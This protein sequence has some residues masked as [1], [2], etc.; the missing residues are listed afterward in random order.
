MRWA[1]SSVAS[2]PLTLVRPRGLRLS[3]SRFAER[4]LRAVWRRGA[5]LERGR[6]VLGEWLRFVFFC[7][8]RLAAA[9]QHN[10]VAAGTHFPCHRVPVTYACAS[11]CSRTR[12]ENWRPM[13]EATR[14]VRLT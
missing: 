10:V 6:G 5:A 4:L 3:V 12:T 13:T 8:M 11:T 2:C 1:D 14:S 7:T 9:A